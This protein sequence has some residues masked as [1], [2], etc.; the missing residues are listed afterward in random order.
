MHCVLINDILI[1]IMTNILS[2]YSFYIVMYHL[3]IEKQALTHLFDKIIM[4]FIVYY[5]W[6]SHK[7]EYLNDVTDETSP[8]VD[9]D[10]TI[11]W[12]IIA[13][14]D[15]SSS[16][17]IN[18]IVIGYNNDD[19]KSYYLS[20]IY[21]TMIFLSIPMTELIFYDINQWIK[22]YFNQ[23]NDK[24]DAYNLKNDAKYQSHGSVHCVS[25]DCI[26]ICIMIIIG[27]AHFVYRLKN[28]SL[29]Q[30]MTLPYH[31]TQVI[32]IFILYSMA[33]YNYYNQKIDFY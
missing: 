32:I 19:Y 18:F 20:I 6:N 29:F 5:Q 26:L 2:T 13:V 28:Y 23:L 33:L 17:F 21:S 1:L 27:I 11:D 31:F 8:D 12:S 16:I 30:E 22:Q 24:L 25:I 10:Q 3:L 14:F 7:Y 9:T 15:R 4:V